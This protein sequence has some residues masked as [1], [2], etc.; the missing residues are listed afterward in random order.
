VQAT[1]CF[2]GCLEEA[3]MVYWKKIEVCLDQSWVVDQRI[4]QNWKKLNSQ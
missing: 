3:D 1:A 4:L 2:Y